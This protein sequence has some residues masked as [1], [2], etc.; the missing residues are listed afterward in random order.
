M[1]VVWIN[2]HDRLST[3]S[4][5]DLNNDNYITYVNRALAIA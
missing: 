5:R 1:E 2:L 4:V 3:T